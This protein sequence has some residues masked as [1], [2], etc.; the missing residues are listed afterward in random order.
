MTSSRVDHEDGTYSIL[1]DNGRVQHWD[2][3]GFVEYSA[4]YIAQNE[5]WLDYYAEKLGLTNEQL[6]S[7]ID[8]WYK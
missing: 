4:E 2:G 7:L 5:R 1:L 6:N 8:D 3:G